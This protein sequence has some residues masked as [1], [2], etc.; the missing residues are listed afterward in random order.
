MPNSPINRGV[1]IRRLILLLAA[2]P[3]VPA[4]TAPA[5]DSQVPPLL[6]ESGPLPSL[7][8]TAI[9]GSYKD[10]P[11]M[12]DGAMGSDAVID[13]QGTPV[14][15]PSSATYDPVRSKAFLPGSIEVR[16]E[17]AVSNQ[18]RNVVVFSGWGEF[19]GG[20]NHEGSKYEATIVASQAY[21]ACYVVLLFFDQEYLL[22]RTENPSAMLAFQKIGDVK[23]GVETKVS[24]DFGYIDP[25]HRTMCYLPL[26]FSRGAEIRTN[27]ADDAARLFRRVEM[28]RHK[29]VLEAYLTKNPRG[30]LPAVPYLRFPPVFPPGIDRAGIPKKLRLDYTVATDGTVEDVLL[31]ETVPTDVLVGVQR[32]LQGWLYFPKLQNGQPVSSAVSI[33]LDF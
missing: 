21:P 25:Q 17:S 8:P 7:H 12:V 23:A 11:H 27:L 6:I 20:I 4:R 15:L 32:A 16:R 2:V 24:A 22:E 29:R 3:G 9:M 18:V 13:N 19:D 28:L 14:R 31:S 33:E 1:S 30:T 26:Y 5:D 10:H